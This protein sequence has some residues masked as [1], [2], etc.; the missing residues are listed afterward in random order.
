MDRERAAPRIWLTVVDTDGDGT[1]D[2]QEYC[3]LDPNKLEPGVCGCGVPDVDS[4]HDGVLDCLDR[5]AVPAM[6][7][8]GMSVLTLL[9]MAALY[10]K[11]HRRPVSR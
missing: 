9:L 11:F 8:W 10:T 6:G 3:P 4:N 1:L 7:S 2:C 5:G